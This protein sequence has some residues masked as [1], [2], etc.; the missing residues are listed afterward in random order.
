MSKIYKNSRFLEFKELYNQGKKLE[1]ITEILNI[2]KQGV[3]YYC[4][5]MG[6]VF[7]GKGSTTVKV[8]TKIITNPF[9]DNP[10][11]WY[12]LGYIA[13]D[14]CVSSKTNTISVISKDIDHLEKYRLFLQKYSEK[15]IKMIS[16][17]KTTECKVVSFGNKVTKEF[18]ISLGITPKKSK[19]L[20]LNFEINRDFLRG[21]FDGDGY[22]PTLKGWKNPKITSN[23]EVFLNQ[24]KTYLNKFEIITYIRKSENCFYIDISRKSIEKFYNL[25]YEGADLF[26]E[27]KYIRMNAIIEKYWKK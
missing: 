13:A 18:L 2:S 23:S 14:G 27:R 1:E 19:T 5:K 20:N 12:W 6:V 26:M 8:K 9:L 7:G 15:E 11:S 16:G 21:V 24:I 25:L 3:W 4:R 22:A 17:G 10:E